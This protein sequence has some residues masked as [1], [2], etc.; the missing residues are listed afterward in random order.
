M[1]LWDIWLHY[2][3]Y[4]LFAF[5]GSVKWLDRFLM[6]PTRNSSFEILLLTDYSTFN[7][8]WDLPTAFR[9]NVA[10]IEYEYM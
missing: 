4:N 8:L 10:S 1:S 6:A 3:D 2:F 9:Y 5:I 7:S